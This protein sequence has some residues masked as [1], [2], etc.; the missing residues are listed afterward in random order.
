MPPVF[1]YFEKL[2]MSL[3]IAWTFYQ[4]LLRRLTF[5]EWNRWYLLGYSCLCF[6]IPLIDVGVVV[7]RGSEPLVIQLIPAI[8][9]YWVRPVGPREQAM[10]FSA[11]DVAFI[12]LAMGAGFFLIRLVV[13]WVSLRRV[14]HGA[15]LIRDGKIRIYQV[16]KTIAPFSFGNAIYI[17][18]QLHTEKEWAEI[19]LHEY[20]HI[21][22]RHSMDIL[23][24]ELL[25]IVNWYNPFAWLIRYSI[26]QNLEFAADRQV[27]GS[28]VDKKGYQYH[29]LKV[30]GDPGYRLANNFNFSSLKKRI[31]MMNKIKSARLHLLKFLFIL[32]LLAVL[33]VAFRNKY[34]GMWKRPSGAVYVNTA[35][36]VEDANNKQPLAGVTVTEKFSGLQVVSD[37][38]GYYKMRIPVVHDSV[39]IRL[40]MKKEGYQD[41]LTET[42][43]PSV[44]SIRGLIVTGALFSQDKSVSP[45]I[46]MNVPSGR[47]PPAD[48]DF[49]DALRAMKELEKTNQDMRQLMQMKKGHPE[50]AMFY[51]AE[52]KKQQI[53]VLKD[54]S[55]EK[56]GYTGGATVADMEMKYGELPDMLKRSVVPVGSGYLSQWER[57]SAQA[58]KAFLTSNPDARRIIFPGDSRVIVVSRPGRADVYDMDNND[59]KERPAFE[60]LYGKLPDCVP[61]PGAG[62]GGGYSVNLGSGVAPASGD[63]ENRGAVGVRADTTRPLVGVVI[64][65]KPLVGVVIEPSKNPKDT[66]GAFPDK[67]LC[68]VDGE[69]KS[70]EFSPDSI[71]PAKIYA[72]DI[73]KGEQALKFYGEKGKNGV[74]VISTKDFMYRHKVIHFGVPVDPSK[75]PLYVIDGVITSDSDALS[76]IKP[77]DIESISVVKDRAGSAIYGEKAK[78]GVIVITMKKKTS[79]Q[80]KITIYGREGPMSVMADT[81]R[82]KVNGES[83]VI[84]ADKL[85]EH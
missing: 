43:F 69:I 57:I 47:M 12:L 39:R 31:I 82:T 85:A 36:M 68:V 27:L 51:T 42:Y 28:G 10:G 34:D 15:R 3:A 78:N 67:V 22:Q 33:L 81:I 4:L 18:P 2:S 65:P 21:R 80:P 66:V 35:G 58:E 13:R 79:Y 20:V 23:F 52:S 71:D 40:V 75:K 49:A 74:I 62:Q 50:V 6:F 72:M 73:L 7:E 46:F 16:G 70:A 25:C 24:G 41:G 60:K 32:P 56:Y 29:L 53:V 55:V 63:G 48:P 1:L 76:K 61:M 84:T 5:Y 30:V 19:I 45:D 14:R 64:E 37:A 11:W 17:N 59:S 54:G 26:R 44:R 38:R 8:G 9:N 77:D 83:V